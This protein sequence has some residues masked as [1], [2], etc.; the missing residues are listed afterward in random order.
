MTIR[1]H[2]LAAGL[3]Q[4][5]LGGV[6][7]ALALP[8]VALADDP[9]PAAK[10]AKKKPDA[11][12][13]GEVVVTSQ[14][15]EQR[16]QEVP[17]TVTVVNDKS[18][19]QHVA[20]DLSDMN[21]F[22][23]GLV[24]SGDSPTQ[25]RYQIRG[26]S[27]GDFGVGTDPAVGVYIDGVYSA[28]SGGAL[29]ALDDIERIEVLKG[30][31]GTLFGRNS[32]A[33]AVSIVTKR[34]G[35]EFEG[36][37]RVRWGSDGLQYFDALLNAPTGEHSALRISALSN[38][39]DG[40]LTDGATGQKYGGDDVWAARASFRWDAS[41]S[42]QLLFTWD[43]EDLNQLARPA[44]GIV[45]LPPYPGLPTYPADPST[46]LDP[47]HASIFNDVVGNEE[48]RT[49]D[50]GTL[51]IEHN[52]DWGSVVST[53]AWRG[54]DTVNREDED[55]TNR[56]NLYFD[57]ANREK[58]RS[59]Y[60]E[61]K[62]SGANDRIDW[63]A[64]L[65]YYDENAHQA[66][67]TNAF[68]DSMD[69]VLNNL[70][71]LPAYSLVEQVLQAYQI[72][73]TL[74]GHSWQE[75]MTNE[76]R[77]KSYAVFGD[78]I[79]HLND[80]FNLTTG[81]RY[82]DDRKD[83][84]WLNGPRVAPELDAALAVLDQ[85]GFFDLDP[86]LQLIRPVFNQDVVFALPADVEGQTIRSRKSWNDFSPRVVLDYH[87]N[88]Q[89]MWFG[90]I[91]K[92]YKAG[93]FNSVEV[94]SQFNNEDVW[95][96]EL[97]FKSGMPDL[98]LQLNGSIYYYV[99]SNKQSIRLDPNTAGSGI[100]QYLVDTSD[101]QAWGVEFEG[102]WQA[103]DALGFQA[104]MA[105]I[106]ATYKD[107]VT[108]TGVDLS[109]EPTGE[110]NWS[111]AFGGNYRWLTRHGDVELSVQSS[112]RGASRC[113]GDSQLQGT[114]Q[115]SPNFRTGAAQQRTDIRLGWT[116]PDDRWAVSV[117]GTNVFDK[118]YVTGVSNLTTSVFGTP[119]ASITPPRAWGVE[120]RA[121]F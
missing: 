1:K 81:L 3:Q 6:V 99:Y 60:Q 97:G 8:G 15:R 32:A 23:P 68:T 40:W 107:K 65:S 34:P 45:A 56:I 116:S 112:Y 9:A 78:V 117:F 39:S 86:L 17:I 77:F 80:H 52:A 93:G 41:D 50:G 76:G 102:Q 114:C 82:T 70:A 27:T 109:G 14:S 118:R 43:H 113:N 66:S 62:F 104:N 36:R 48:S 83:F 120:L 5:L 7:M 87:P 10:D 59:W 26:I 88:D 33:G 37:A 89:L 29:L 2:R 98:R 84:S 74:F 54:F 63:V 85:A 38:K 24:V 44:I 115:V 100:P 94:G 57:T 25:P 108:S 18:I 101:E 75:T 58:N 22:I 20:I 35:D 121:S 55:G 79:W 111:F 106:D 72:P 16:L 31:Q 91:A 28:R 46:Y 21:G 49:F 13:L 53:T 51:S 96:Y 71:G 105:Y 69:T 12:S 30:P 64:G 4:A 90:S 67:E 42:T 73:V 11:A 103:T 95:N 119:N 110:P 61:F 19:D 92:G 47:L